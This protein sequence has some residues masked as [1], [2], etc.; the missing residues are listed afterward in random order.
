MHHLT[1]HSYEYANNDLIHGHYVQ[2]MY[3][4]YKCVIHY[5]YITS[6]SLIAKILYINDYFVIE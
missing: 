3:M 1:T 2:N 5:L 6:Y 4:Q